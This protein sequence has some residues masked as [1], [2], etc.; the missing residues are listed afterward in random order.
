MNPINQE[1]EVSTSSYTS[2]TVRQ[3]LAQSAERAQEEVLRIDKLE[4]TIP[5][6]LLDLTPD[7]VWEKYGFHIHF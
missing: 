4:H 6:K 1:Q 5:A 3:R 7:Q 2:L